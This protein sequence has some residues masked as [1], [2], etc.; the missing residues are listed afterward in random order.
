MSEP[1]VSY[2]ARGTVAIVTLNRPDNKSMGGR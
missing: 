2:E 1:V